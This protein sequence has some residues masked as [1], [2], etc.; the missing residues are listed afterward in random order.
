MIAIAVVATVRVGA[1]MRRG[2]QCRCAGI[3]V[4]GAAGLMGVVGVLA[5]LGAIVLYLVPGLRV[6]AE[7]DRA[8]RTVRVGRRK[9]P[10]HDIRRFAFAPS[11][12]RMRSLRIE[13]TDGAAI[14][15]WTAT[16]AQSDAFEALAA[17]LNAVVTHGVGAAPPDADAAT[18]AQPM[19]QRFRTQVILAIGILWTVGGLFF[20]RGLSFASRLQPDAVQIPVWSAGILILMLGVVDW[21]RSRRR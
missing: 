3:F 20:F 9:V 1:A 17:Q 12:E 18:P 5:L 2:R 6:F 8:V 16:P 21:L 14:L 4:I 10:F 11:S 15:L 13:T 19:D 7:V